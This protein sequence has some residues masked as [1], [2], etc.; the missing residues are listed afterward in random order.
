MAIGTTAAILGSAI[1]GGGAS[2]LGSKKNS[3]AINKATA[4]QTDSSNQQ[5][6]Y[7]RE[8]DQRNLGALSP[9]MQRGNVAGDTINAALG[10][11]GNFAVQGGGALSPQQQVQSP[12]QAAASAY[13]LF[14]ESTGYSTRLQEGQR[15]Q[16]ALYGANGVYQSGAR[17][18]A[19]ARFNQNFASGEFGN[20]MSMLGNQQGLGLAGAS[21][22]AGVSQGSA[23]RM[24]AISQNNATM[25]GQA[26]V[27]R[28]Q[29]T[30]ALYTGLAGIAGQAA[31][32]LSSYQRPQLPAAN[33]PLFGMPARTVPHYG[34]G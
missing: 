18:K 33:G 11:G 25:A 5:I 29:N 34:Y 30:G 17:D 32:A 19:L 21:A 20:W 8:A 31:G 12:G 10:I 9:F 6:A 13:E 2:I 3:K 16:G 27:A 14:K 15:G 24:G 22:L 4:A 1:I 28:A 23:D 7:Q 26:A